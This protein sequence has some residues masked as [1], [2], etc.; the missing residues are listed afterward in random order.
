MKDILNYLF[1]QNVLNK[2][3]ARDV[4]T[5]IAQGNYSDPEIAA[6][7]TIYRMRRIATAELIG[8]R[9][10][11][12]DLCVHVDF[13][14]FNTI[15]VCGTG[16]DGKN[17]FNISTA[18]AFVIAGTGMKVVKHGN[19][20]VSSP[21]GSSNLLEHFGYAFSNDADKLRKELDKT[22]ICYLHAPLFHPSM[23]NV[24]PVRKSLKIKTFFNM[25]G[26]MVNPAKPQNQIVGV[27][28][29][30]VLEQYHLV[31]KELGVNYY[32]LYSLDGY[33]EISLT[34]KFRAISKGEDKVYSPTDLKLS[35]VKPEDLFGGN[36]IE[37]ARAIFTSILEGNGTKAQQEAVLANAAFALKCYSPEKSLNECIAIARDS[38]ND[39]KALEVLNR[40]IELQ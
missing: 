34:G 37:E 30:E 31:Y 39:G 28:D 22:N 14:G 17:T 35:Q 21:C 26:P 29:E 1:A 25:L 19:Y 15:D 9:E 33:D 40:L 12:L 20:G 8:F 36:T 18:T 32:I 13:S 10:A 24:G 4:L 11:M 2:N 27:F 38:I 3:E 5:K 23:K 16:G 7:L 6:F